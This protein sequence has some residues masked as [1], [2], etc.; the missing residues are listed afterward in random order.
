M[1]SPHELP[2]TLTRNHALEY[3]HACFVVVI[4]ITTV[5][6]TATSNADQGAH[7]AL[8]QLV[9]L[10]S[11]RVTSTLGGFHVSPSRC[12]QVAPDEQAAAVAG[13]HGGGGAV[14][15]ERVEN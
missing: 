4:I 10:A 8:R 6:I 15:L 3:P 12:R 11:S 2:T 1:C 14:S 13:W 7:G 9:E 5:G